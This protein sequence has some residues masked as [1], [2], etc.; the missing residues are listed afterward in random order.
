MTTPPNTPTAG[1]DG[2]G[3]PET[4]AEAGP[5]NFPTEGDWVCA[6]FARRLEKDRNALRGQ[7]EELEREEQRVRDLALAQWG[8][9][10][11]S[12]QQ[13]IDQLAAANAALAQMTKDIESGFMAG[14]YA[15]L[16]NLQESERQLAA[17]NAA[18]EEARKERERE[19]QRADQEELAAAK[20][21]KTIF[22]LR[23]QLAAA[24]AAGEE[25][26]ES[27]QK[28]QSSSLYFERR[29]NAYRARFGWQADIEDPS[30]DAARLLAGNSS[31]RDKIGGFMPQ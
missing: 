23:A 17:A 16:K 5:M 12:H 4:D 3:T 11:E 20:Y 2:T 7:V 18:L 1:N 22:D 31:L 28:M 15:R 9:M 21:S 19:K 10:R 30:I 8:E 14:A 29:T 6:D 27:F 13:T 25:K 24:Q 26:D